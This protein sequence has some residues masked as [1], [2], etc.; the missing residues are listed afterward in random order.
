MTEMILNL[1]A[2]KNVDPAFEKRSTDPV[3]LPQPSGNYKFILNLYSGG[4]IPC[5]QGFAD[6]DSVFFTVSFATPID[7][8]EGKNRL[9]MVNYDDGKLQI[10]SFPSEFQNA[11]LQIFNLAGQLI[12]S[13]MKNME[14]AIPVE[15]S[16][17]IYLVSIANHSGRLTSRLMVK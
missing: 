4:S 17:G 16:S 15:L 12:F 7:N 2:D 13:K 6:M 5:N 9:F 3:I 11:D 10:I 8:L 1:G 14:S